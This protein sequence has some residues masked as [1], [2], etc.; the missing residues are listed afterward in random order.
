MNRKTKL[1][2]SLLFVFVLNVQIVHG[3]VLENTIGRARVNKLVV[4]E[5]GARYSL[6]KGEKVR[7]AARTNDKIYF[8]DT[9][10]YTFD[11]DI[12]D[13]ELIRQGENFNNILDEKTT[14]RNDV[15]NSA[16]FK[17]NIPYVYGGSGPNSYDCSGFTYQIYKK[18]LGIN[19]NR[20]SRDQFKN[21][22]GVSKD[23]LLPG[24]LVF[25][26][27]NGK[28]INHVGIYIGDGN[29]IHASSGAK[30]VIVSSLNTPWYKSRYAGARRLIY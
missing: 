9:Q 24:D 1:L 13:I 5:E 26:K 7:V 27:S 11:V 22:I 10:G 15:I 12:K 8:V 16:F 2:L 4:N 20:V 29:M 17:L 18:E 19:L 21:G 14:R 6:V 23:N 3:E 25:F 30:K 28:V